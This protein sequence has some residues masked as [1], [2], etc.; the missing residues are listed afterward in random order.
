MLVRFHGGRLDQQTRDMPGGRYYL[1][2]IAWDKQEV[3]NPVYVKDGV[4]HAYFLKTE[5]IP[6]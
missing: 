2:V 3:Y 5:R 6:A 4:I 1:N